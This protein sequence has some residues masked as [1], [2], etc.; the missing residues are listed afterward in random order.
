MHTMPALMHSTAGAPI[1]LLGVR[2]G[3]VIDDLITAVTLEHRYANREAQPV[4][5]VYTFPV[6]TEAALHV[7]RVAFGGE[8]Y[9]AA[10]AE[11]RAAE[12]AYEEAIERAD[13]AVML[14]NP[15]PGLYTL[16]IGNLPAGEEVRIEVA[17][18]VAHRWVGDTLRLCVPTVIGQRYGRSPLSPHETPFTDFFASHAFDF[19]VRVTGAL[20]DV[21][22]DCPSHAITRAPADGGAVLGLQSLAAFLDRDLVIVFRR[23]AGT[24]TAAL[25]RDTFTAGSRAADAVSPAIAAAAP[26]N[27]AAT[28]HVLMLSFTPTTPAVVTPEARCVKVVLDCS[29]SMEGESIRQARDALHELLASLHDGDYLDVIRFGSHCE[30][31]FDQPVRV[32]HAL[33]RRLAGPI[34]SIDADLGGTQIEDA[35]AM[36]W[37]RRAP[38][39]LRGEIVLVTDGMVHDWHP[40]IAQAE[41]HG[42]RIFSVGVGSAPAEGFIRGLARATGG[43]AEF[44]TPGERMREVIVRQCE[45]LRLPR[46]QRVAVDWPATPTRVVG[47][48]QNDF[49]AGDTQCC[50]AWF[51]AAPPAGDVRVTVTL[52]G[53]ATST[54]V[55]HL[56]QAEEEAAEGTARAPRTRCRSPGLIAR[57]AAR[58]FVQAS[59][60]RAAVLAC[61]LRYGLASAYTN[62][63]LTRVLADGEGAAFPASRRVPQMHAAGWGGLGAPDMDVACSAPSPA[64]MDFLME[65]PCAPSAAEAPNLPGAARAEA[66]GEADHRAPSERRSP[67]VRRRRGPGDREDVVADGNS[68]AG[69]WD[70]TASCQ[71]PIDP[72]EHPAG[73][74]ERVAS[75]LATLARQ[76]RQDE[77][78]FWQDDACPAGAH[79]W[80]RDLARLGVPLDIR[81]ILGSLVAAGHLSAREAVLA[82]LQYALRRA[83]R[84]LPAG[85]PRVSAAARRAVR[86]ALDDAG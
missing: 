75:Q 77:F 69:P 64:C 42:E 65:A 70:P 60:D 86:Q 66:R 63:L 51:D 82:L 39:G 10:A 56:D 6:P 29:G 23:P 78:G 5:V 68:E 15:E 24:A 11:K 58:H 61:A 2:A 57:L 52:E 18:A 35:L 19:E 54:Q 76:Q 36:A 67:Y 31:M 38:E 28:D 74:H 59:D 53:G 55:L 44:V 80:E 81:N 30:P 83:G 72:V 17:Y 73:W 22:F 7:M 20:A 79:T 16:S 26:A 48:S 4:E 41:R 21:P 14:A 84:R 12:Q 33:R 32:D 34:A 85:L 45:R 3:I 13:A 43:L 50:F 46:A 47:L 49:F 8:V 40:L 25:C 62:L 9:E 1:P 71:D 37:A 27:D